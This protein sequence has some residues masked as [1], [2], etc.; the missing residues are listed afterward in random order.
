MD[1][2]EYLAQ[3]VEIKLSGDPSR[4]GELFENEIVFKELISLG[5]NS[6]WYH[7]ESK[8][9]DGWYLVQSNGVYLSYYQ[10]RGGRYHEKR[11]ETLKEA[12]EYFYAYSRYFAS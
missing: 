1:V 6:D 9:F 5:K 3:E 2:L 11:F 7:Y 12:A 8:T 4:I 10:E